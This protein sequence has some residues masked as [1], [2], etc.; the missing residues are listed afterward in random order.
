LHP[1]Y[2]GDEDRAVAQSIQ[3]LKKIAA[4]VELESALAKS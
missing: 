1:D 3:E 2:N 4:A